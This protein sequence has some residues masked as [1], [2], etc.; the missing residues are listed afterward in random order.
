MAGSPTVTLRH[1]VTALIFHDV[2]PREQRGA[3]GF[4]GP[5]PDRYK[6]SP[7]R[8][9]DHLA[10]VIGSGNKRVVLTFD[11][12]GAS[13][14]TTVAPALEARGLRGHFFIPTAFVGTPGFVDA[15]GL[16]RLRQAG[17]IVG[18]HGHTHAILTR[19]SPEEVATEW[20]TSKATLEQI[21][22]EQ[23]TMMSVPRGY[24]TDAILASAGDAGFRDVFTSEPRRRSRR[25][26]AA[27]VHGRFS[28]VESTSPAQVRALCAGSPLALARATGGWLARRAAKRA[29]GPAY[30]A[31]RTRLL[32]R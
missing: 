27:T 30:D 19:L 15:A 21:L 6:L 22:G 4:Q 25:A 32:S 18:A 29:L 10:S 24:V 2:V 12:G 3:S 14:V 5:G 7:E 13:A 28:V 31:L 23:V 8:F 20:R 1:A 26:G 17:H 9:D 16:R 11:D